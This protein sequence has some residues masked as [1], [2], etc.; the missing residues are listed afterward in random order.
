MRL[1]K[2]KS[3]MDP[4]F[5]RDDGIAKCLLLGYAF[6]CAT[7]AV[8]SGLPW[9]IWES[10]SRLATIDATDAVLERSSHC[11]DGCRYDRSN[12]GPEDPAENPYPLRWLYRDGDE[13]VVFDERGPGAVTRLWMTTGF[14]ASSCID[15]AIRVRFYFDGAPSPA[16]DL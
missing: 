2:V 1:R 9:E 6:L 7:S 3:K 15:P 4:G 8:A 12:P 16:L 5:R 13:A 11:L 14:G 10:P